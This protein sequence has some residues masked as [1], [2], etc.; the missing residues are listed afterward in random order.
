MSSDFPLSHSQLVELAK[1]F[2]TP[3]YIMM[4]KQSAKM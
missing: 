3:F 4:K 2:P 1:K